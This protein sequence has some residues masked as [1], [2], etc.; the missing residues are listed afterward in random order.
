MRFSRKIAAIIVLC[1]FLIGITAVL[2]VQ[3]KKSMRIDENALVQPK[4][5]TID[6]SIDKTKANQIIRA[7]RLYYT[8]WDTGE[9][10]YLDAVMT[11]TFVIN[12]LPKDQP[13]GAKGLKL[14]SYNLRRA[15]PDLRCAV[16]ELIV[17][18]DKVT[19]RLVYTGTSKGEFM[20]HPPTEKPVQFT[21]IDILQI[22]NGKLVEDWHAEDS[23]S[24]LQQLDILK[25]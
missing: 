4:S 13:Q 19:A 3:V 8:F 18:S 9:Y 21:A 24:L 12:P 16:E 14:A 7:A 17:T 20:N 15:M 11:P 23:F 2:V 22:D 1:L 25:L 6:H 5:I 10:K